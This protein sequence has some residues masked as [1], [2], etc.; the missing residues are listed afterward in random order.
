V[1]EKIRVGLIGANANRGWG[2]TVHLP[3]IR[4]LNDQ[5]EITAVCNSSQ[6]SADEAA[7]KFGIPRAFC[8]ARLMAEQ[9]NVDL[10]AIAVKVPAHYELA[11]AVLEA[12]KHVMCE[13]PLAQDTSKAQLMVEM[14]EQKGVVH[15]LGLQ[16]R[17]SPVINRVKDLVDQGYIGRV[18]SATM[19]ASANFGGNKIHSQ[20][21]YTTDVTNGANLLTVVGG[22][23][24][25]A[26]NYC[27][28]EFQELSAMLV[29]ENKQV[30]LTDTGETVANSSPDQILVQGLLEGGATASIHIQGNT[31]NGTRMLFEINGTSGDLRVSS[32]DQLSL[33]MSE[34]RLEGS[35]APGAS[36]T[37]LEVPAH[38]RW[39]PSE[40]APGRVFNMAQLYSRLAECI[41]GD[42]AGDPNFFLGLQRHRML[43]AIVKA[44]ETGHRQ[45]L[46]GE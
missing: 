13:W 20:N 22:H 28:G 31:V 2:S 16:S 33:Q 5:Y 39:V 7:K 29:V 15:A 34:L 9:P 12:G 42:K 3:A 23:S 46:R 27:L 24:I 17:L 36:W 35:T 19:F 25:D 10:V 38:Y 4:A 32:R 43:D 21:A 44:S 40:Q 30:V 14:A 41:H 8:D 1:N 45:N 37:D 26:L 11:K 6:A 18:Q